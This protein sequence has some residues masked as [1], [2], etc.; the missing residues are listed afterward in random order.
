MHDLDDLLAGR[1]AGQN[2]LAKRALFRALDEILRHPVIHVGFEQ[3]QT[4]LAQRI[5]DVLFRQLAVATQGLE[6][7]LQFL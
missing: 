6:D 1:D 4:H 5:G 7:R 3:G 2:L